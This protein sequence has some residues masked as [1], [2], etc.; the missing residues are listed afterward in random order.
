MTERYD[1]LVKPRFAEIEAWLASGLTEA[2]IIKNLGVGKTT[3]GAYKKKHSDLSDLLKKGAKCQVS[4]VENALYKSSTGYHYNEEQAFKCKKVF[5]DDEGHRCEEE[6]VKTTVVK[7]FKPP[8]TAAM[9]FF[10]KNKDK[11]NWGDNPQMTDI[12]RQE[13]EHKIEMDDKFKDW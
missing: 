10:L 12:R 3:W 8:E 7:K 13:L 6:E 11:G 2:Q 4:E 9:A 1:S 5:Y